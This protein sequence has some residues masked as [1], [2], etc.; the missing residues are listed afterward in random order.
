[1][2]ALYKLLATNKFS[3]LHKY[4]WNRFWDIFS[5]SNYFFF[6]TNDSVF[7]TYNNDVF[8]DF[9]ADVKTDHHNDH[10]YGED[11]NYEDIFNDNRYWGDKGG[12]Y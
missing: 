3:F 1:M 7:T 6:Q 2:V 8:D 9:D 11:S 10:D 12:C 4:S 5:V